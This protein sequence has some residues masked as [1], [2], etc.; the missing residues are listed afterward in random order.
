MKANSMNPDQSAEQSVLG[1]FSLQY[2]LPK[3]IRADDKI[4]NWL[5]K[6]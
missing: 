4:R 1:P 6:D 5:E 2:M 3:K